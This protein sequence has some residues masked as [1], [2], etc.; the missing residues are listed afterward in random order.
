MA[1]GWAME[2]G[3]RRQREA[4]M[5]SPRRLPLAVVRETPEYEGWF[6]K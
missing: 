1:T 4:Y 6:K 2:R 5:L 3:R